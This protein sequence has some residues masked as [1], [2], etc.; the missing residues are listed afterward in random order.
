ME[1]AFHL[2][3]HQQKALSAGT[4][5]AETMCITGNSWLTSAQKGAL[6]VCQQLIK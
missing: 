5:D 6:M 1:L 4:V 3:Y 2:A